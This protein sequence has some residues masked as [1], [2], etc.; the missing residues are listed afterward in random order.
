MTI[1]KKVTKTYKKHRKT[2]AE[3]ATDREIGERIKEVRVEIAGL[4]QRQFGAR[5]GVT[6][7][8]VA[9]WENGTATCT[10]PY[11]DKIV[12]LFS[13]SRDWLHTGKGSPRLASVVDEMRLLSRPRAE[14]VE[15][16]VRFLLDEQAN[17]KKD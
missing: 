2:E 15:A 17:E 8:A 3:I 9:Q 7:P 14:A 13:V 16:Y 12:E 1:K 11:L 5:L 4:D 6:N 10:R